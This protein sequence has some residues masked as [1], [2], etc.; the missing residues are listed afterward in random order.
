MKKYI[1]ITLQVE[2]VHNWPSCTIE[3]VA[4]LQ[5]IHRHVFHIECTK[6]VNHDDRDIEFICFKRD[7][8]KYLSKR[9]KL[10]H[11]SAIDF[12]SYSC[13]KIALDLINKFNLKQCKVLEDNEN[14]AMLVN[15]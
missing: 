1:I 6:Q 3:T 2:G 15:E 10:H 12:G 13:E 4:Y 5:N 11:N 14:G 9:Y 7:V 8:L